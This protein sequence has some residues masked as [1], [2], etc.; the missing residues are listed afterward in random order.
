MAGE[1][2]ESSASSGAAPQPALEREEKAEGGPETKGGLSKA[3]RDRLIVDN[4]GLVRFVAI[5]VLGN[6]P[7]HVE[8]DDLISAGNQGLVDAADKFEPRKN[9]SFKHY[10]RHRIKG[11]ILDSLRN[12]DWA[13]RQ[14][15]KDMKLVEAVL[16]RKGLDPRVSNLPNKEI[17]EILGVDGL[18]AESSNKRVMAVQNGLRKST[19]S[20]TPGLDKD[21]SPP[22]QFL[23]ARRDIDPEASA[24]SRQRWAVLKEAMANV[25]LPKHGERA[26]TLYYQGD[27]EMKE[28]VKIIGVK[29]SRV[30]QILK[31]SRQ[32]LEEYL[33]EKYDITSAKQI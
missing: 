18:D 6:L 16:V 9:D 12:V 17:A 1:F 3:E 19:V 28:I 20:L 11:A 25:D 31:E 33:K 30:S 23:D 5:K 24:I 15:R 21:G 22:Q 26:L 29:E 7:F 32:L 14:Q 8:L 10:A 4:L 13:S 2:S 27:M